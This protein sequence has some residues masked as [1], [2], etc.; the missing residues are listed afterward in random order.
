MRP[1][2]KQTEVGAIPEDWQLR[3]VGAMGEVVTGKAL[4]ATSFLALDE[5]MTAQEAIDS[6]RAAGEGAPSILYLYV[7]DAERC[8]RGVVPIRRLVAAPPQRPVSS[9][10]RL[11][12]MASTV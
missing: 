5:K 7:V 11:E 1:G 3:P 12:T 6:L 9:A 10:A 2:Y 4:A 8:L